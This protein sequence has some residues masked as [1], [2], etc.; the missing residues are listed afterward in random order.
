M[1]LLSLVQFPKTM[2]RAQA[3]TAVPL[4]KVYRL[5][6]RPER[7]VYKCCN[8]LMS[9]SRAQTTVVLAMSADGKIADRDRNAA[10]FSSEQ[11]RRH[12]ETE[13]SRMDGVLFGASTLR[14]YG[15]CLPIRNPDLIAQRENRQKPHQPVQIVCSKSGNLDSG[16]QFFQQSV[17]RWLLTTPANAQ[18]WE[19]KDCFTKCIPLLNEA[20][21][22]WSLILQSFYRSGIHQLAV[23]GGG[24]LVASLLEQDLI[25][26]LSLTLCP[27]L[28]GG[29][30]AP[31]PIDGAGLP[32][33]L[34]QKL[35]L[36]QAKVVGEEVFLRYRRP[37]L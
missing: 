26:H 36:M 13:I 22:D 6:R 16:L 2:R 11:D 18:A 29:K 4:K 30:T 3:S 17:P 31:T 19:A 27:I 12:L 7:S 33:E 1:T 5:G 28:L 32:A 37:R 15:T 20:V 14:A 34:A 23:L 35:K 21:A 10:R 24:T 25:D 9:P 8:L